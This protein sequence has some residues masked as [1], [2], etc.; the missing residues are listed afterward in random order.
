MG[1]NLACKETQYLKRVQS[2]KKQI[3]N[4]EIDTNFKA[5]NLGLHIV[6]S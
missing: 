5:H 6:D 4:M 1:N 2:L 3:L